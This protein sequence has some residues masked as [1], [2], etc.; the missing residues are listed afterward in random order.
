MVQRDILPPDLPPRILL[1]NNNPEPSILR[2]AL[3]DEQTAAAHQL[4]QL[5][6][7]RIQA[8]TEA[9]IADLDARRSEAEARKRKA[10]AEIQRLEAGDGASGG[11]G[12]GFKVGGQFDMGA[13]LSRTMDD[14]KEKIGL[15]EQQIGA[16]SSEADK[17]K[18]DM[19]SQLMMQQI[20][21]LKSKLGTSAA[22]S[23]IEVFTQLKAMNEMIKEQAND[24]IRAQ[25]REVVR[26]PEISGEVRLQIQS[27]QHSHDIALKTLD[28]Q[29]SENDKKWQLEL[30]R[31]D[32]ELAKFNLERQ[33]KREEREQDEKRRR[34]N[35]GYME[36]L[37][38]GVSKVIT[39]Q[40]GNGQVAEHT[41]AE[42]TVVSEPQP[43]TARSE[44]I[45]MAT[46][47]CDTP[48]CGEKFPV[49]VG[50][51]EVTCPKCNIKQELIWPEAA[52]GA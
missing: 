20:N 24:I 27:A 21:D 23:P 41:V 14:Q 15:L 46:A 4:E 33:D 3:Q 52:L 29:M 5:G 48:G 8:K 10:E 49:Q 31:F 45:R 42:R 9:E 11:G 43:E 7:Q 1:S 30:K 40:G 13:F 12:G 44:P 16:V 2:R 22:P 37:L 18:F 6:L 25:P 38:I 50:M 32:L 36:S 34:E 39:A 19:F 28:L 51:R 26:E 47:T 17:S 35:L